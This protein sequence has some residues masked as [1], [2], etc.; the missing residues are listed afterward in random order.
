MNKLILFP[1]IFFIMSCQYFKRNTVYEPS[2]Y[3]N[4][5]ET[6]VVLIRSQQLEEAEGLLKELYVSAQTADPELSTKALFELAQINEKK[7][8]WLLALSQFKE[9]ELKK[10]NLQG[11]KAELELPARLAGL[12]ATLGE[13]QISEIY[14]KKIE[15]NLQIYLQQVSLTKQTSWWAETFFRMGSFPAHYINAENWQD[16]ARRFHSTSQ[17]L[18][19]SMELSDAVWSERSLELTQTFFKKSF[20]FLSL[21]PRDLEENNVLLGSIVRE[22]INLLQEILQKIQLYRPINLEKSRTVWRF[23][24]FAGDYQNQLQTILSRI[25]DST[26]L[27]KESQQRNAVEREGILANPSPSGIDKNSNDPN[28]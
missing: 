20:E 17:Y 5:W 23:Y 16:F 14:A 2:Y 1:L 7:G 21:S 26:P 18:I 10:N 8:E 9:C 11:Y 25:K 12:Y 24:Q 3:E 15:S 13:L 22:R 28:L 19:R 4:Q 6:A 27:S